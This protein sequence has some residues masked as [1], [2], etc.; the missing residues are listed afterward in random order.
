MMLPFL[1]CIIIDR[2]TINKYRYIFH[3]IHVKLVTNLMQIHIQ[4]G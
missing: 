2:D 1:D 4:F 3:D